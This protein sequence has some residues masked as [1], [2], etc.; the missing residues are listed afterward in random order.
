MGSGGESGIISRSSS[1]KIVIMVHAKIISGLKYGLFILLFL[2]IA[3]VLEGRI[4][5]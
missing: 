3:I 2:Q 1:I 4:E 5:E